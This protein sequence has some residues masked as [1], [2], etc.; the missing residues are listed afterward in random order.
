[1]KLRSLGLTD[2]RNYERM[3]F[4][5]ES[6]TTVLV[7]PNAVGKTNVLEAVHLL[8]TGDSFR[9]RKI[10]EMVRWGEEAGHV[11]GKLAMSDTQTSNDLE[12]L[13]VVL[14]RGMVQGKRAAKRRYQV[15]GVGKRKK[16]FVGRLVTVTFTPE[17]LRLIV[18]SPSRRR[19]FL[20][21]VLVQVDREY[22]RS[23]ASYEKGLRRRNKVLDDIAEGKTKAS[24][25]TFWNTLLVKEGNVLTRKREELVDFLNTGAVLMGRR[26]VVYEPSTISE[27]R[28]TKYARREL[29]AGYTLIG[30]HKDDFTVVALEEGERRDL[31]VYGS[32]GEQRMAVLWMK[33]GQLAYVEE[34]MGVRPVLLLDDVFSELDAEHEEVLMGVLGEQQSL[35]TATEV[36]SH[37]KSRH[38]HLIR[39]EEDE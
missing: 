26:S 5:F 35:I 20:D 15:N 30:P 29:A 31:S 18:G 6:D 4:Q 11:V 1:M 21:D 39:L 19:D 28:L 25:L 13:H 3:Q 38:V 32:R 23:L 9:A 17:D 22:R 37:L 10:E 16:D 27:T 8:A 14:T 2:F 7:G 12:T 36:H 34:Q 24:A 33:M